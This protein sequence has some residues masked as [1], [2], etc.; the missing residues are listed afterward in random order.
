MRGERCQPVDNFLVIEYARPVMAVKVKIPRSDAEEALIRLM[1]L[2]DRLWRASDAR[3]AAFGLTDNQ[4][5]VLRILNGAGEPLP[6]AEIGRR[7]LSSRANVTKLIDSLESRGYVKRLA[8]GDRRMKLVALTDAGAKFLAES[9][10]EV[11]GFAE[12]VMR[13]LA[14]QERRALIE[15]LDKLRVD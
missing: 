5:N 6:Q 13:P 12:E 2:G 14:R 10:P 11:I 3:F 4:Y 8:C 15:L 1:R 7:L 9:L